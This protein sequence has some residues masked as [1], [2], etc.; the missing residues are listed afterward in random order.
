MQK[1]ALSRGF[2]CWRP[3]ALGFRVLCH[4]GTGSML[5]H[6]DSNGG[7]MKR[8]IETCNAWGLRKCSGAKSIAGNVAGLLALVSLSACGDAIYD[9]IELM[10]PPAVYV[11]GEVDPF[12]GVNESNYSDEAIAFY[13]TDRRPATE[14][15]AQRFYAN[16]RGFAL[17]AGTVRVQADPPFSGWEEIKAVS[18]S[19][20]DSQRRLLRIRTVDEHGFLPVDTISILPNAPSAQEKREG[21]GRF[22]RAINDRLA[23]T[24]QN[25]I[26]IYVHGYN[27]DFEYPVLSAKELQHYMGYRGAFITY[28]WPA[29]PNRLAY[30]KDLETADSTRKNLRQFIELLSQ[31]TGADNIHIIG[32]SAGSRLA[33]EAVYDLALQYPEGR[34]GAPRL[35]KLILIGSDVD[36]SYFA[37]ALD[38]GILRLTDEIAVYM[39]STDAALRMSSLVLGVDRLGQVFEAQTENEIEI[40]RG[41]R[42]T[43]GLTLIDVS[44]AEGSAFGN[45]HSYFRSSPWA[46][47]DMFVSLIYDLDAET[48]GLQQLS[49]DSPVW[50]FPSDYPARIVSAVKNR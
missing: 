21:G 35:G 40:G 26:F 9:T 11:A 50:S 3:G 7:V 28:A 49:P 33:F 8:D 2:F 29:T 48:R 43:E 42:A 24:V 46:S 39:S 10:P 41:L 44:G 14:E 18:L 6:S 45:G 13:V 1:A 22:M 12:P 19:Q 30:F 27:V 5:T 4:S 36:R 47:S 34:S 15:D 20:Q 32:Y 16:E 37:Q 17:R 31:N 38:D 23:A 25:D